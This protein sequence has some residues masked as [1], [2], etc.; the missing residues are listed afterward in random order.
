MRQCLPIF[1]VV[2]LTLALTSCF[3]GPSPG[4]V[5]PAPTGYLEIQIGLGETSD[6]TGEFSSSGEFSAASSHVLPIS[7]GGP[8]HVVSVVDGVGLEVKWQQA[9]ESHYH[10]EKPEIIFE[11]FEWVV[12]NELEYRNE[13]RSYRWS[14]PQVQAFSRE[15][16]LLITP[17]SIDTSTEDSPTLVIRGR[18]VDANP[19]FRKLD[20]AAVMGESG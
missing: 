15:W 17:V 6:E 7:S 11:G 20:L 4:S 1:L 9:K 18:W 2:I 3:R 10:E 16:D 13:T 12:R 14:S 5:E 19:P 8:Q